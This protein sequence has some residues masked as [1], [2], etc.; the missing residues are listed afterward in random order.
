VTKRCKTRLSAWRRHFETWRA[1][2]IIYWRRLR[3]RSISETR[4]RWTPQLHSRWSLSMLLMY[5]S[6]IILNTEMKETSK[7]SNKKSDSETWL[8]ESWESASRSS[9]IGRSEN[10]SCSEKGKPGRLK[11]ESSGSRLKMLKERECSCY[12]KMRR[13]VQLNKKRSSKRLRLEQE[14]R[15]KDLRDLTRI[16]KQ[17]LLA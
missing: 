9:K 8:S 16:R 1:N 13:N 15:M 12:L 6:K 14:K 17:H 4:G 5:P 7:H 3:R 2:R 11:S 10:L